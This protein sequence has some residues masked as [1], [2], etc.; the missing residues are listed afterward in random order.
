[1]QDFSGTEQR[2]GRD[3]APVEADATEML[4]LDDCR[5]EAELRRADGGHIAAGAGADD[6]NV[7]GRHGYSL[8]RLR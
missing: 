1:V 7:V 5:L 3:A 6:E 8:A 4:A 2:F